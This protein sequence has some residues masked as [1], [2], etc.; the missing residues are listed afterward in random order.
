[1]AKKKARKKRGPNILEI[2]VR[3]VELPKGTTARQYFAGLKKALRTQ[4]LPEGWKVDLAWRNPNTI[5]GRTKNWQQ[6]PFTTALRESRKGFTTVVRKILAKHAGE[7][8][9]PTKRA[10]AK[11]GLGWALPLKKRTAAQKRVAANQERVEAQ[12]R[13]AQRSA[14]SKKGWI[15]RRANRRIKTI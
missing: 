12:N 11:D 1:M 10:P 5:K 8:P 6:A 14:A 13:Y 2:K 3:K 9:P 7:L 4:E 15:T